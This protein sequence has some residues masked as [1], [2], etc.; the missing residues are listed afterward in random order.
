LIRISHRVNSKEKLTSLSPDFGVEI[1]VRS[2]GSQL[3]LDHDFPANGDLL[4]DYLASFTHKLLV[5][6]VKEDGLEDEILGLP[7]FQKVEDYFFL[8]QPP[9]TML[10]SSKR[11]LSTSIRVSEYEDLPRRETGASW[12]WIDSFTGDWAH[13][14]EAL[15]YAI[16]FNLKTCLVAPELQGRFQRDESVELMSSYGNR[17]DAVCTKN[18]DLWQ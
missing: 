1:D 4:N 13:L 16:Q 5:I 7:N 10:K 9:P 3:V 14:D 11:G 2:V 6:N 18:L 15:L 12:M 8:D 17:L